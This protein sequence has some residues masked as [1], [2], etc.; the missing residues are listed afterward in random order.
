MFASFNISKAL[1]MFSDI[2]AIRGLIYNAR[3]L[4]AR[5]LRVPPR[6][7]AANNSRLL[8]D[9]QRPR[10]IASRMIGATV[11]FEIPL[12]LQYFP[13][14]QADR[15][16]CPLLALQPQQQSAMFSL[17]TILASLMI[18]SQLA[19]FLLDTWADVNGSRQ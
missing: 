5:F 1:V 19:T 14:N 8:I 4:G 10:S 11:A 2:S 7:S 9:T 6:I 13:L 17:V 3:L 16:F 12:S 18:C 15:P